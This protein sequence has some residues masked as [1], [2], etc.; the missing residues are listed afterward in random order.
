M[1]ATQATETCR[2]LN[3]KKKRCE[4]EANETSQRKDEYH[5][6]LVAVMLQLANGLA[7]AVS[8]VRNKRNESAFPQQKQNQFQKIFVL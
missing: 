4:Q 3:N 5:L 7:P 8:S 2:F 6:S 1:P